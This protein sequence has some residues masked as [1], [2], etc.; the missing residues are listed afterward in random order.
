MTISKCCSRS[1][2]A[3]GDK[4]DAASKVIEAPSESPIA[5]NWRLGR[6]KSGDMM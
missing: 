3:I 1:F 2:D 5:V 4:I 6:T